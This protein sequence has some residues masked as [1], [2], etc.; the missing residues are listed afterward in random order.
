MVLFCSYEYWL[1]AKQDAGDI[2]SN[3]Q[4]S[5]GH[6]DKLG[7]HNTSECLEAVARNV[8]EQSHSVKNGC[9]MEADTDVITSQMKSEDSDLFR[10]HFGSLSTTHKV[11]N[12]ACNRTM[13]V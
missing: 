12:L 8:A 9:E 13:Q 6:G 11:C 10:Q 4:C 1:L 5:F 7:K 3:G 2:P